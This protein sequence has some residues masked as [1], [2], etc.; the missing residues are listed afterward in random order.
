[1]VKLEFSLLVALLI[2]ASSDAA[3]IQVCVEKREGGVDTDLSGAAV[4]CWDED[5]ANGDDAMTGTSY[6]GSNGCVTLSYTKKTPKWY[7]PC[8]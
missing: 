7:N 1:M 3:S 8:T 2:A 6:T 5:F 4:K